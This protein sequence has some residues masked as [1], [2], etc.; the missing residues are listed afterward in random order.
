MVRPSVAILHSSDLIE[1]WLDHLEL[2]LRDVEQDLMGSWMFG[3]ADALSRV[4]IGTVFVFITRRVSKPER[5]VHRP[6]GAVIRLF[7]PPRLY[8]WLQ[9]YAARVPFRRAA[10]T[11]MRQLGS[12]VA[13]P[14]TGIARAIRQERCE[15]ILCQEY[16]CPRFDLAVVVGRLLGLPVFPSFHGGDGRSSLEG[17]LH[18]I[19]VRACAGVVISADFEVRRAQRRYRIPPH[20]LAR[21]PNP[22][23]LEV[24]SPDDRAEARGALNLPA[25]ARVAV[26]HGAVY[27]ETKGLDTLVEAW[28]RVGRAMP[29]RDLRLL[30]VGGGADADRLEELLRRSGV[31]GVRFQ[32]RWRHDRLVL[33]RYLSAGDLYVFPSRFEGYPNALLEA[34]ACGLPVIATDIAGVPDIVG[35]TDAAGGILV[36]RA[37]P[38][39]LAA[40]IQ[41][42]FADDEARAALARRA[43]ARV[44][45]RFALDVVGAQLRDFFVRG[46]MRLDGA[47][48]PGI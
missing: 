33:R 27:L 40:A 6:T 31:R 47:K 7:P 14:L 43:R 4:G 29:D 46:G 9:D 25:D 38:E 16:E 12:Y 15:A 34:M 41:D 36:R 10:D 22:I 1:E 19:T 42:L 21:V 45:D 26:W 17:L 13:T 11:G 28:E 32:N 48:E 20:K 18:P 24:W 37:D 23:D 39:S 2:S 30:L 5:T 44:N 35:R 3:Y 8:S